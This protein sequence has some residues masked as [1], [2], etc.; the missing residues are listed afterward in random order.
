MTVQPMG[1]QHGP[2]DRDRD[3]VDLQVSVDAQGRLVLRYTSEVHRHARLAIHYRGVGDRGSGNVPTR[4]CFAL[5][6]TIG[7]ARAEP[8]KRTVRLLGDDQGM[9]ISGIDVNN[10][11]LEDGSYYVKLGTADDAEFM[12]QVI[13]L[14]GMSYDAASSVLKFR[15][16]YSYN[17]WYVYVS[18][19]GWAHA[20]VSASI[21]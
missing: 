7:W 14:P 1:L 3:V 19:G 16:S 13:R 5:L 6:Q 12:M 18:D 15:N 4:N 9:Q 17:L 2:A 8:Q 10:I 20:E 11:K 21:E